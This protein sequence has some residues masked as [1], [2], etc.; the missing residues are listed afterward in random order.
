[1][2]SLYLIVIN[3]MNFRMPLGPPSTTTKLSPSEGHNKTEDVQKTN[4]TNTCKT[5]KHLTI[6]D[7]KELKNRISVNALS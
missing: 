2:S 7:E 4:S 6:S 1:M 3:L 5:Y